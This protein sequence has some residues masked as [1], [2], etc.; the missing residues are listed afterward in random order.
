MSEGQPVTDELTISLVR[1]DPWFRLQRAV[2]LIPSGGL[3]I[4][5]RCLFFAMVTWL[6]IVIWALYWRRV[7]PGE[8]A[9]P[10]LQHFGVHVR[11]LV[12]I[13]L[14]VM[15]ERAGDQVPRGIVSY[16]VNSGLVHDDA[17]PQFI[18]ILRSTERLRDAWPAWMAMLG[19]VLSAVIA[20]PDL[21]HLHELLWASE[22]DAGTPRFGFGAW[23]F[24]F[25]MRPLVLWLLLIWAWR[26]VVC[27][28]LLWRTSRLPLH[29]VP[30][31]PDRVGGLGFLEDIPVI[32]SPVIFALS[33]ILAS[34][35]G[36]EVLYHGVD[37][38]S[39]AI[40]LAVY[41]ATLLIL[42]LGPLVVFTRKLQQL[43]RHSLREY[44]ALV[45]QHGR[46]VRRRWISKE[47]LPE[48]PLLQ[49][50]ELGPVID[51]VSMY[52]VVAQ[53]RPAPIGKHALLAVA[54]PALLPM[55]PVV[56][57]QIPLKDLLL[58]LLKTV[59]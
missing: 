24:L 2:G 23:W 59:V 53:I 13:P 41:L 50:A 47:P 46:L 37:V 19:I 38:H 48:S 43:K 16:F 4:P 57:I 54:L 36:H 7:F 31:H 30:T 34:R 6:P 28:M 44:G 52:E 35:W 15:A 1:N 12:A 40:P 49:A 33:A 14:L 56:A 11:C 8:V 29:F 51:T 27:A 25:V 26:L 42:V 20:G 58:Q 39:F 32:F 17:R 55:L 18:Q 3:G 5:R 10:L 21:E 22:N 45:G 9:E